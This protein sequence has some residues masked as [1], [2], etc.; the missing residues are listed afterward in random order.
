MSRQIES[1]KEV[2]S[3]MTSGFSNIISLHLV[4]RKAY[5][6]IRRINAGTVTVSVTVTAPAAENR[7]LPLSSNIR[8]PS[9]RKIS[10]FSSICMVFQKN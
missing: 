3:T 8:C 6:P 2:L 5:A 1:R 9:V 10:F 7:V 4:P